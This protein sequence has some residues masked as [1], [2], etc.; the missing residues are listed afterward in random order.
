MSYNLQL[1]IMLQQSAYLVLLLADC[2]FIYPQNFFLVNPQA[3]G[4][5]QQQ[6]ICIALLALQQVLYLIL[7]S[8]HVDITISHGLIWKEGNKISR[9]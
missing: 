9:L 6:N 5:Q 8:I 4:C 2:Y 7:S 1:E 3:V